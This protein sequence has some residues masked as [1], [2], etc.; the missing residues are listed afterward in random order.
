MPFLK[1][2]VLTVLPRRELFLEPPPCSASRAR[3]SLQSSA[4]PSLLDPVGLVTFSL[5][6][7]ATLGDAIA[8]VIG[9]REA[10]EETRRN[11][12]L[13]GTLRLLEDDAPGRASPADSFCSRSF[14][15]Y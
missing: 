1:V 7:P 6:L 14:V 11:G 15:S 3:K 8:F 10:L 9:F 13:R 4:S 12:L 2:G 5:K